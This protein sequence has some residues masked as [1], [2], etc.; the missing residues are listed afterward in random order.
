M[1]MAL[2]TFL[3][4]SI[5]I[6][7]L[8]YET[9]VYNGVVWRQ[10]DQ[11][12]ARLLA[13]SGLRLALLQ[14]RA[15]EK[16]KE[17]AKALGL[18][19]SATITDMI[20]KTPLILPP[21]APAGL[22]EVETQALNAFSKSL[23]LD[24]VVSVTIAG[25][26]NRIS[27]NQLVWAKNAPKEGGTLAPGSAQPTQTAEQKKEL[28]DKSRQSLATIINQLLETK[29]Q[30]DE[31]FRDRHGTTTGELLVGNL[32]AWMDPATTVDGENREK[33]DYYSRLEPTPYSIKNAP[34]ATE[35][36]LFMVKGFDD[37]LARLIADNFT[38]QSTGG[39]NV[40]EATADL[41]RAIIPE[42]GDLDVER[43]LKRR[44]DET[45]GGA[46]K[47]ADD[48]WAFLQ[49]LGNFDDAKKRI[50]ELGISL[51]D[52]ETSYRVVITAQS[53]NANKTW[54]ALIGAKPPKVDPETP[55]VPGAAQPVAPE[56]DISAPIE[57]I[58]K[59]AEEK[60][61]TAKNDSNSL[62]IIYL[63][64]D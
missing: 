29:R 61:K 35:T 59:D 13:R 31:A 2:V 3:V 55:A 20:W 19:D 11:L 36:E 22:G 60:K 9:G 26:N 32:A 38:I 45:Q 6:G 51:L 14:V 41:L 25:E 58:A 62:N 52:K 64:A 44:T 4:L 49:T 34:M 18:G 21:P 30:S 5:L 43:I 42:L 7:E 28:L 12:R 10:A 24:G 39:L 54:V 57:D 47:S 40:N 53:G 37:S 46:F 56:G 15:A 23:G 8:A 17:K 63:K 33:L 50:T 1:M 27:L 16:A 48:F